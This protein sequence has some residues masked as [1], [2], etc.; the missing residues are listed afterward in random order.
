M[1]TCFAR[2]EPGLSANQQQPI[3]EPCQTARS[4]TPSAARQCYHQCVS[5]RPLPIQHLL[6]PSCTAILGHGNCFPCVFLLSRVGKPLASPGPAWFKCLAAQT[7]ED[8]CTDA[9]VQPSNPS[10]CLAC[11]VP[12]R[13]CIIAFPHF[14]VPPSRSNLSGVAT[15]C[16]DHSECYF[17][18][19]EG[20]MW[21]SRSLR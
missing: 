8:G 11:A 21:T 19:P 17:E 13:S 16:R 3:G 20:R 12:Q 2:E 7:F 15:L 18:I 6:Q 5:L 9:S 14:L 1:G 10:S 4:D